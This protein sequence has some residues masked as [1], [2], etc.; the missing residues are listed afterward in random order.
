M[1]DWHQSLHPLNYTTLDQA[2]T[3]FLLDYCTGFLTSYIHS[4]L[5]LTL[6]SLLPTHFSLYFNS[7]VIN[8][9]LFKISNSLPLL[10]EKICSL[11]YVFQGSMVPLGQ[12]NSLISFHTT[13]L[14]VHSEP[15]WTPCNSLNT[16]SW[17]SFQSFYIFYC[18]CIEYSS[19]KFYIQ[20]CKML[21][22]Q[23]GLLWPTPTLV[24]LYP[25][26]QLYFLH[27]V[28]SKMILS[29]LFVF[30]FIVSFILQVSS[31]I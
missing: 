20:D 2:T 14:L 23:K 21:H 28:F 6:P 9:P 29:Y 11:Y 1:I 31:I 13:L 26:S 5:P 22:P 10:S 18:L 16:P 15:C 25:L 4:C 30:S 19:S 7:Q 27:S 12:T 3:I 8:T 17:L 24:H